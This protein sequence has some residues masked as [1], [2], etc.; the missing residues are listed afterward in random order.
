V[1][2]LG[3]RAVSARAP[4]EEL[5]GR[6]IIAKIAVIDRAENRETRLIL[7][8]SVHHDIAVSEPN[9]VLFHLAATTTIYPSIEKAKSIRVAPV[10]EN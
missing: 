10:Q 2:L 9:A 6:G 7:E 3:I 8:T 5:V 1:P 4:V